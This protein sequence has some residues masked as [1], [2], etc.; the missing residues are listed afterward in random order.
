MVRSHRFIVE[1]TLLF[2]LAAQSASAQQKDLR[3]IRLSVFRIDSAIV[4]AK[5]NGYLQ[6]KV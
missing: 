3:K 4:A 6:P 2:L 1:I 5:V